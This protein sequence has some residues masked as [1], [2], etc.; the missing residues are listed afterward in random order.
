[1]SSD[2]SK[3]GKAEQRTDWAEDRTLMANER[4]I[5]SWIGLALGAVGIAIALKA[6]FGAFEPTWAAKLVASLFLLVAIWVYWSAERLAR[7]THDRLTAHHAKPVATKN[8]RAICAMLSVA[9]VAVG[10]VLWMI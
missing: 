6:V 7:L 10:A 9:T 4:T 3:S 8:F 1:M 2:D 5:N